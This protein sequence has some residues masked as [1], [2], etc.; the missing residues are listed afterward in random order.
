MISLTAKKHATQ[1]C[2]CVL[3]GDTLL[4]VNKIVPSEILSELVVIES[5]CAVLAFP[6]SV[7]LKQPSKY[8]PGLCFCCRLGSITFFSSDLGLLQVIWSFACLPCLCLPPV[9]SR[10]PSLPGLVIPDLPIS[11]LFPF[12]CILASCASSFVSRFVF[13]FFLSAHCH[14]FLSHQ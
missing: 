2:W 8:C 11:Q 6:S 14:L 10:C 1:R 7:K 5:L 13:S 9:W 3:T 12:T 4:C